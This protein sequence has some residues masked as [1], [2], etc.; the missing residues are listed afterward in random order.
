MLNHPCS[1]VAHTFKPFAYQFDGDRE[2][3]VQKNQMRL[4]E[5]W[6]DDWKKY[7][8]AA[9]YNWPTKHTYLTEDEKRS[10]DK[11]KIMKK[12]L[13][14]T[15]FKWY[16]ENIIPEVPSPPLDAVF[17]GEVFNLKSENCFYVAS[18][19]YVALTNF[20]FFHR[21]VPQNIF[22]IDRDG[23]LMFRNHCVF[24][25]PSIA[26]LRIGDCTN[27]N[28]PREEWDVERHS[29][30]EGVLTVTVHTEPP[31]K[32]C[33]TQVTN[34][35]PVHYYKQMPQ[36]LPCEPGNWFQKWRWTYKFD[37]D[38]NWEKPEKTQ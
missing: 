7:F 25:D 27:T 5:L 32:L 28:R 20:C 12:N 3:I 34:V 1:R 22:Y 36:A 11:R 13:N 29:E 23:R 4:A 15:T 16:M 37:Y 10:L 31:K 6:M 2:K 14:C 35:N 18:D 17:Y 30:V 19:G 21:L 38:Y 26:L 8:L 33:A 24:V 9:T